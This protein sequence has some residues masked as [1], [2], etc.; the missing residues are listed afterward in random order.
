MLLSIT[1][2]EPLFF[3]CFCWK[4]KKER[5]KKVRNPPPQCSANCSFIYKASD[6][7]SWYR[8]EGHIWNPIHRHPSKADGLKAYDAEKSH[9]IWTLAK[10]GG[11]LNFGDESTPRGKTLHLL[12]MATSSKH[13]NGTD[14]IYLYIEVHLQSRRERLHMLEGKNR[15]RRSLWMEILSKSFE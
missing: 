12:T 15:D 8:I 5:N 1:K 4:V 6:R 14:L 7:S 2:Q 11:W 13:I 3:K 10:M 9:V